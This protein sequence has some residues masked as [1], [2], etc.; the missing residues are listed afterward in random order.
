MPLSALAIIH[1][2]IITVLRLFKCYYYNA[3]I[4]I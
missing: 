1:G 4:T 3:I 2:F